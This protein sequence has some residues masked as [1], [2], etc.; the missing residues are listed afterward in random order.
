M[1]AA[2]PPDL[3][4]LYPPPSEDIQKAV[5]SQL[6]PFHVAYLKAAT[7]FCLATG[8]GAGLDASPRGGPPGFAG[9]ILGHG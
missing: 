9:G 6:T 2:D 5:F 7:F 3:D 8:R 4:Q 1:Q